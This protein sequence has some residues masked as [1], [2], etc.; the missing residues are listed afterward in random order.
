MFKSNLS[1]ISKGRYKLEEEKNALENMKLLYKSREAVI[2]L[3]NSCST[4]VSE[5]K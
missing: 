3:F 5:A 4:I 1:E 2:K